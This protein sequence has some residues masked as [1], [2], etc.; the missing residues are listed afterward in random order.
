MRKIVLTV[1][2]FV[3]VA[4]AIFAAS[5][6]AISLNGQVAIY[7]SRDEFQIALIAIASELRNLM[8]QGVPIYFGISVGGVDLGEK[9]VSPDITIYIWEVNRNIPTDEQLRLAIQEGYWF[10]ESIGVPKFIPARTGSFQ[11]LR[12]GNFSYIS[13]RGHHY[14]VKLS[15][16]GRN[17]NVWNF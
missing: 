17:H 16:A 6:W 13:I 9:P 5:E 10:G 3:V 11:N 8:W 4:S 1:A 7:S 14:I 12:N 15:L 2:L